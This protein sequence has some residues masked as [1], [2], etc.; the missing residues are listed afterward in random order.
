MLEAP[1]IVQTQSSATSLSDDEVTQHGQNFYP[2]MLPL[3]VFDGEP[4][5]SS[6]RFRN[7]RTAMLPS[8]SSASAAV[9]EVESFRDNWVPGSVVR[10][11]QVVRTSVLASL[12]CVSAKASPAI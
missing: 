11:G 9:L 2:P 6:H 8:T 1:D 4:L 5:R 7:M 12:S 3:S 10:F